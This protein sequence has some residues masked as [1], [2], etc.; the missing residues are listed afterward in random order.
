MH[1]TYMEACARDF[2]HTR[3]TL[4][5]RAA[6]VLHGLMEGEAMGEEG[7]GR[8]DKD[9]GKRGRREKGGR[10][11]KGRREEAEGTEE[12]NHTTK[13]GE[14]ELQGG[15][16]ERGGRG[17]GRG[18]YFGGACCAGHPWGGVGGG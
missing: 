2:A 5:L 13:G 16:W 1:V 11:C 4:S 18:R 9:G 15:V 14:T 12:D 8:G 10:D 7:R 6:L 17:M 3:A